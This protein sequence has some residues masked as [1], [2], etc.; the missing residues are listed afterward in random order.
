DAVNTQWHP[1]GVL[2]QDCFFTNEIRGG[3]IW[4][5]GTDHVYLGNTMRD[6]RQENLIRTGEPQ[7][8]ER[9]LLAY[10]DLYRPSNFKGSI[11]IRCGAWFTIYGNHVQNGSLRVG[12]QEQDKTAYPD[13]ASVKCRYGWVEDNLAEGVFVNTRLGTEH[14]VYRNN[15]VRYEGGLEG[16]LVECIKP[17]YD[18]VRKAIDV[19]ILKNTV[20]EN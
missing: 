16:F 13:W 19:R 6:S 18:D 17:G 20:V 12:P 3:P 8:V 15:L 1:T 10:N 4:G 9:L 2:V 7:G 5:Q 11:E 14:C